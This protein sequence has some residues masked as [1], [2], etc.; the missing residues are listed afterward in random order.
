MLTPRARKASRSVDQTKQAVLDKIAE[1]REQVSR[2]LPPPATV[3]LGEY[4][5]GKFR[6]PHVPGSGP[7]APFL[8]L[9]EPDEA[10]AAADQRADTLFER[11]KQ[12]RIVVGGASGSGK[13][14]LALRML[15]RHAGLFFVC[16]D[17]VAATEKNEGSMDLTDMVK[18]LE[19]SLVQAP[20]VGE[21]A[22]RAR[23][24]LAEFGAE[25]LV[26]SRCLVLDAWLAKYPGGQVTARAWLLLQL[27]AVQF[28]RTD[29]FLT[30]FQR[31]INAVWT[32]HSHLLSSFDR[33]A[34]VEALRSS[35]SPRVG[36]IAVEVTVLDESQ[37][38]I[39][40]LVDQF[41][42]LPLEPSSTRPASLGKRFLLSPVAQGVFNATAQ[43]P[44]FMGTSMN[45]LVATKSAASGAQDFTPKNHIFADFP[46]VTPELV[47]HIL[48]RDLDLNAV[49][50]L[51]VPLARNWL[52][53]RHRTVSG[54][55]LEAVS[56]GP[57]RLWQT[58]AEYVRKSTA[59]SGHSRGF[60][61]LISRFKTRGPSV[62]GVP[63][64]D[65]STAWAA[66]Q[67]SAFAQINGFSFP[68]VVRREV[69]ILSDVALDPGLVA[70]L[71]AVEQ[72]TT[73]L[74]V[75]DDIVRLWPLEPLVLEAF[76][77]NFVELDKWIASGVDAS[78]RGKR[79]EFFTPWFAPFA[80][81]NTCQLVDLD[82]VSRAFFSARANA[83]LKATLAPAMAGCWRALPAQFGKVG[84]C[85]KDEQ[86]FFDWVESCVARLKRCA[87]AGDDEQAREF[88]LAGDPFIAYPSNK[89]RPDGAQFI[90]RW[91][92]EAGT[93]RRAREE[94]RFAFVAYQYK[95]GA[96]VNLSEA[97]LTTDPAN[98]CHANLGS[99]KSIAPELA[100]RHEAFIASLAPFPVVRIVVSAVDDL[101]K[102]AEAV[103]HGRAGALYAHDLELLVSGEQSLKEGFGDQVGRAL[104][105]MG[106]GGA[107]RR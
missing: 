102:R 81:D 62:Q 67:E 29:I 49:D 85:P 63:G 99:D 1:L 57:G 46:P 5:V 104:W 69:P 86:A 39:S 66:F 87:A 78:A 60:H 83:R 70:D 45:M 73:M 42:R 92:L 100:P 28:C 27:F 40:S 50:E 35:T 22:V 21:G 103:A 95:M 13:T 84:V 44:V 15:D 3:T 59:A 107:A 88:A 65:G 19:L 91:V 43:H 54:F 36:E 17:T 34:A 6:A 4:T 93:W 23:R 41:D 7:P 2:V 12:R 48:R 64:V 18:T 82:M 47:E 61:A 97:L 105:S 101:G 68:R 14:W 51:V 106:P 32:D 58:L 96:A 8:H 33:I 75:K 38:L 25:C 52:A 56:A 90:E 74:E 16:K 11:T 79:V 55:V 77:L 72:G 26:F 53:G 20:F 24:E 37:R 76:R 31:L 80:P 9:R 98:F 10:S 71:L 94:P 89:V 30:T